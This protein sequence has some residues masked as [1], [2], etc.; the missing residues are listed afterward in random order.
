MR[1][2][3]IDAVVT[4]QARQSIEE[5][6]WLLHLAR[7]TPAIAGVVGWLPLL[8]H[9]FGAHLERL[10]VGTVAQGAEACSAG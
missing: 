4:V 6:E 9:D 7:Q 8:S 2:A 10:R 5:T 3:S 1:T